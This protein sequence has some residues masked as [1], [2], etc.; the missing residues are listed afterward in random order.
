MTP[1]RHACAFGD[2]VE[3]PGCRAPIVRRI[4]DGRALNMDLTPHDC[5]RGDD[6]ADYQAALLKGREEGVWPWYA[7][8]RRR[9]EE[10]EAR[11]RDLEAAMYAEWVDFRTRYGI[12]DAGEAALPEDWP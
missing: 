5:P 8:Q 9:R 6:E 12:P 2:L 4:P 7:A 3:C 10:A 11:E 1:P